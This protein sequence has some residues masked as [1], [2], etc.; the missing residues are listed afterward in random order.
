MLFALT[1]CVEFSHLLNFFSL[2]FIFYW[3]EQV[4]YTIMRNSRTTSLGYY[5][6]EYF[7]VTDS[8]PPLPSSFTF[9]E[10]IC[11]TFTKYTTMT[12]SGYSRSAVNDFCCMDFLLYYV[13]TVPSSSHS[14]TTTVHNSLQQNKIRCSDMSRDIPKSESKVLMLNPIF[15][16]FMWL[17]EPVTFMFIFLF[18]VIIWYNIG[19]LIKGE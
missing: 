2:Y 5:L 9:S 10:T 3:I 4:G 12:S 18:I 16:K 19:S 7:S 15:N 6:S 14:T 8:T 13:Y 17:F 1:V 11:T